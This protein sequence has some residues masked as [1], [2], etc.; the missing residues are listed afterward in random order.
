[1]KEIIKNLLIN[2]LDK[3]KD[4]EL[5]LFPISQEKD[6]YTI[7]NLSTEDLNKEIYKVKRKIEDFGKNFK[8]ILQVLGIF[9]ATS[10]IS[11]FLMFFIEGAGTLFL[12][13][14]VSILLSSKKTFKIYLRLARH[15]NYYSFLLNQNQNN[16]NNTNNKQNYTSYA[17]D[18]NKFKYLVNIK[19]KDE[20]K[21]KF[22]DFSKK[23]HPDAAGGNDEDFKILNNEYM[24]LKNK[25]V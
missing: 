3:I 9:M 17:N 4:I 5:K 6:I 25:F 1:M 14:V 11:F 21:K 16:T 15:L 20:L 2:F 24:I 19:S 23:L 12:T 8:K 10:F 22:K 18:F 7:K 13:L